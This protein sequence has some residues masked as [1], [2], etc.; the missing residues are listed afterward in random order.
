MASPTGASA[1]R[2]CCRS[3]AGACATT[4]SRRS[5]PIGWRI[6]SSGSVARTESTCWSSGR[7][8]CR[9]R[10]TAISRWGRP[11]EYQSYTLQPGGEPLRDAVVDI[12]VRDLGGERLPDDSSDF[13]RRVRVRGKTV[14][15]AVLGSP[16]YVHVTFDGT[17][18]DPQVMSAIAATVDAALASGQ[19]DRAL[20]Y[21]SKV[22]RLR[23]STAGCRRDQLSSFSA[24]PFHRT[25]CPAFSAALAM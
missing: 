17:D 15:V 3:T 7:T 18:G 21:R 19:Y 23:F 20:S 9:C 6:T 14:S 5:I 8:S 2:T 12:L 4:P 10:T 22:T 11:G 16:S 13:R 1:G 25:R 24:D